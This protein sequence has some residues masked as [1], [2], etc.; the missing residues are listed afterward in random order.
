MWRISRREGEWKN[1]FTQVLEISRAISTLNSNA[2]RGARGVFLSD[3]SVDRERSR[4]L[5]NLDDTLGPRTKD[6]G[7]PG[8]TKIVLRRLLET[9]CIVSSS[10]TRPSLAPRAHY[11]K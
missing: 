6:R 7:P 8:P 11:W 4:M 1:K 3:S 10:G 5:F 2:T 9:A